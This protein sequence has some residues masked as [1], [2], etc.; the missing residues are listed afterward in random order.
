MQLI[1]KMPFAEFRHRFLNAVSNANKHDIF[2]MASSLAYTTA[3]ALAPFLLIIL[4]FASLLS[5]DLQQNIYEGLTV[6]VGDKI[7]DTILA[8]IE[9][10]DKHPKLSGMS[11][12]IGVS[13]LAISA[14]AIFSNLKIALDK[15]NEHA[16]TKEASGLWLFV[17]GRLFSMGLVFGFSFLSVASLVF[18][19]VIA[20]FYPDGM[21]AFW[22][23]VSFAVNFSVFALVFSA[24]Y[25]FVPTDRATWKSCIISGVMSTIFYL[26][27]KKLIGLYLGRAGLESSYG[28]A[29]SLIV[30]LVWVYYTALTLLFSYE[31]TRDVILKQDL[32]TEQNIE[33]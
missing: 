7:A 14:S 5:P 27:G 9:N 4:S 6:A 19:M 13:V 28:A 15:I 23:F 32:T 8:M 11:G 22:G 3:L 29:G 18:T 10:A 12:V 31:F 2:V 21:G 1:R 17:K 33:T 30:L 20:I 25:R 26:V 16:F 24:I